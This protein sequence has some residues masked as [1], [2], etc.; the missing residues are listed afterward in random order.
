MKEL[1]TLQVECA[2]NFDIKNLTSFKIGGKIA[3]VY[4][5]KNIDEFIAVLKSEP[6]A[7]VFGNL[8]NTLV[9]SY[10]YD[11]AVILTTKM[12]NIEINGNTVQADSGVKGPLLSK[13]AAENGLSGLEF[14]IGFPGSV[15]GE[16]TMNAS[17]NGQSVSDTL[18]SA[19]LY[20]KEQGVFTLSNKEMNFSYRHS[21]CQENPF[22]VLRAEFVLKPAD[23]N[24][25]NKK[26]QENIAFRKAH[27]PSLVLPNCGSVFK[28]PIN[29]SA[30]KLLDECNAKSLVVNGAKIWENH[31]NFIVNESSG[32]SEDVLNLMF[33]MFSLV[34][35]KFG[36]E[37]EP[38]VRFL[39]GNNENEVELCK[40]LYR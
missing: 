10:G 7:K 26:M 35:E 39:G 31:A 16:I 8:S 38:E 4:F 36:I 21:I 1:Q 6:N 28:N 40:I 32:T 25:I 18:N 14:M 34:K 33:K 19:V 37:L 29:N 2:E 3:R 15:G 9:S 30:G 27:Q 17:A 24:I 12:N 5:P 13:K 11:G 22:I 23:M 20:S